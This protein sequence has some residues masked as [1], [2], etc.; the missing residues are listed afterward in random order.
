MPSVVSAVKFGASSPSR[1]GILGPPRCFRVCRFAGYPAKS[2]NASERVRKST[3]RRC[4][5]ERYRLTAPVRRGEVTP[6]DR[7]REGAGGRSDDHQWVLGHAVA[8]KARDQVRRPPRGVV[9][10]RR[11]RSHARSAPRRCAG[12]T[13]SAR[14]CRRHRLLRDAPRRAR[15]PLSDDGARARA[16]RRLV[17]RVAEEDVGS[18]HR[19]RLRRRAAHRASTPG[20]S[21]TRCARS[22]RRGRV[23]AS[24]TASP[25]ARNR[26][27]HPGEAA[28]S[29]ASRSPASERP[30]AGYPGSQGASE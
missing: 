13:S 28:T 11:L 25:T 8:T 15:A 16:G 5:A 29:G 1:I 30:R 27:A 20:S 4:N 9:R 7:G 6:A 18:R 14:L 24:S 19:S 12:P 26:V 2:E 23:C 17:G 22:T 3:G 10:A 21:T